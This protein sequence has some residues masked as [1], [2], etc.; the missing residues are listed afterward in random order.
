MKCEFLRFQFYDAVVDLQT[1]SKS[2]SSYERGDSIYNGV[3][4][5]HLYIG[6]KTTR[7][8]ISKLYRCMNECLRSPLQSVL[9]F[10]FDTV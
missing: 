8:E 2:K 4:H 3:T 1:L 9:S 6:G 5:S 7:H 10:D